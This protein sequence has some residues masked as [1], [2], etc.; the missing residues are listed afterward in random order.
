MVSRKNK[1]SSILQML[2]LAG[3]VCPENLPE[4]KSAK[5]NTE[6]FSVL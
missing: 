5:E 1:W 2:I 3:S 6:E 4:E